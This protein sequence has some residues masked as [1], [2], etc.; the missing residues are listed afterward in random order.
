MAAPIMYHACSLLADGMARSAQLTNR[1]SLR[2]SE[3][4]WVGEYTFLGIRKPR[5]TVVLRDG[6]RIGWVDV[7]EG[8]NILD[9]GT[10]RILGIEKDDMDVQ[11]V[12]VYQIIKE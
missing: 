7:P 12:S 10:D 5:Y 6:T 9:I 2:T 4:A 8:F 1:I 11:A 3:N